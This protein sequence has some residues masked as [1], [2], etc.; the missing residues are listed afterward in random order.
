MLPQVL[1]S[2]LK[3]ARAHRVTKNFPDYNEASL[4]SDEGINKGCGTPY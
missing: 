1:I 3:T 2:I 4:I